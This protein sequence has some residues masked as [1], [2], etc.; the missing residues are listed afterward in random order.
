MI[1]ASAAFVESSDELGNVSISYSE[2]N[3]TQE[4]QKEYGREVQIFEKLIGELKKF[5]IDLK[6]I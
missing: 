4:A 5:I 2:E 3:L 1:N 6:Y